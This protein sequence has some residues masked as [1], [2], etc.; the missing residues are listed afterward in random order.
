M[1]G[2]DFLVFRLA[3]AMGSWGDIAVGERRA[4]WDIPSKSAILGLVAAGLGLDREDAAAHQSLD[5]GLGFAVRQDAHGAAVNRSLRDYH[6]AQAPKA[7]KNARWRTRHD[8]LAE[9]SDD[10]STILSE[11]FYRLEIAVT[12]ALWR[13]SSEP[14]PDLARLEQGLKAPR[15][16]PYL[17]RKSCPLS[18]PPRPH[19][20]EADGLFA[21]LEAYDAREADSDSTLRRWFPKPQSASPRP[22]WFEWGAGLTAEEA[23]VLE[24]RQRRDGL[25]N[26][27]LWQFTDRTEGRLDWPA[28]GGLTS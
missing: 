8:E 20:I 5:R 2:R 7:R 14:G 13:R 21:A 24:R 22:V 9:A 16:V 18:R 12:I 17:G 26:R 27:A 10:L 6:T 28:P 11:R 19:Y 1:S 3:G 4:S 25:T 15:F 23:K